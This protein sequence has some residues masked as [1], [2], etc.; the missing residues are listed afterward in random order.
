[1]GQKGNNGQFCTKPQRPQRL[2]ASQP[3]ALTSLPQDELLLLSDFSLKRRWGIFPPFYS[4]LGQLILCPASDWEWQLRLLLFCCISYGL[5]K[6]NIKRRKEKSSDP[7]MEVCSVTDACLTK[8]CFQGKGCAKSCSSGDWTYAWWPHSYAVYVNWHHGLV[9]LFTAGLEW[10]WWRKRLLCGFLQGTSG[11]PHSVSF[12]GLSGLTANHPEQR[13][14]WKRRRRKRNKRR[15]RRR[16]RGMVHPSFAVFQSSARLVAKPCEPWCEPPQPQLACSFPQAQT[17]ALLQL[18]GQ[19]LWL[20][21]KSWPDSCNF[22]KPSTGCFAEQP[23]IVPASPLLSPLFFAEVDTPLSAKYWPFYGR[24]NSKHCLLVSLPQT[25]KQNSSR[26]TAECLSNKNSFSSSEKA[27]VFILLGI[28]L[29]LDWS[30]EG[31]FLCHCILWEHQEFPEVKLICNSWGYD[32]CIR[33]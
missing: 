15:M 17:E 33:K 6:Q 18:L 30:A 24:L 10:G 13:S 5:K 4:F 32:L 11:C 3:G 26:T 16:R 25:R 7:F 8:S 31:C 28:T 14:T 19:A 27:R 21:E 29:T 2:F 22:R 23:I 9:Q 20:I 12:S 1:M